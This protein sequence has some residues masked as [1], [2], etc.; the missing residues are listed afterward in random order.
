MS[1]PIRAPTTELGIG[2]FEVEDG[3]KNLPEFNLRDLVP[4]DSENSEDSDP[5]PDAIGSLGT[6]QINSGHLCLFEFLFC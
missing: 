4:K 3:T 5:P 2:P 1:A 6:T